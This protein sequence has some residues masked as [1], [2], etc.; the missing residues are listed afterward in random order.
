MWQG[1]RSSR[2]PS[3]SFRP[4]LTMVFNS[5]PSGLDVR[6]RPA[7][8][9]RKNRRPE[10]GLAAGLAAFDFRFVDDIELIPSFPIVRFVVQF[11]RDL[12]IKAGAPPRQLKRA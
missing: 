11:L 4:S 10:T 2:I 7:A 1:A 6:T 12:F 8:R 3:G 5:E 9:S